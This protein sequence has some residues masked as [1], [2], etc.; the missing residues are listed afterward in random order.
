ML[1]VDVRVAG[2]NLNYNSQFI[3]FILF[4]RHEC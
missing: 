2:G 1:E 3:S 4:R